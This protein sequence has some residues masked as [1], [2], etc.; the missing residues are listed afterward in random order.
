[1]AENGSG[2]LYDKVWARHVV[3]EYNDGTSLLY[4]DRHLVQE[5]SSPQ[6]FAG[7]RDAGRD[8]R[9]PD[10]HIAVADHAVS[11]TVRSHVSLASGLAARQVAR[12]VDNA[13]RFGIPYV[14]M[15]DRRHGIVHVIGPELGFILPG[16]V[17]VV[18]VAPLR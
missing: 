16:A 2:T 3:K 7:L 4:V 17:L 15:A 13:D 18:L 8:L 12:L 1:M 14:P 11:T 5:V 9:R 6:A 10:A